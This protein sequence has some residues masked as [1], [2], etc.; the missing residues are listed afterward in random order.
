MDIIWRKKTGYLK[1]SKLAARLTNK[2][3]I[4][5]VNKVLADK[6]KLFEK[7]KELSLEFIKLAFTLENN[8]LDGDFLELKL[9]TLGSDTQLRKI[10]NKFNSTQDAL[11]IKNANFIYDLENEFIN[12]NIF[13]KV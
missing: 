5:E 9:A 11:K 7:N 6:I 2:D 8:I 13:L 1:V 12:S 3:G 10:L 4:L